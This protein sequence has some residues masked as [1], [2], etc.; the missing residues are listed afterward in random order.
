MKHIDWL[1][2]A[3]GIAGSVL[4]IEGYLQ[5]II[6]FLAILASLVSLSINIAKWWKKAKKDGKIDVEEMDELQSII[7]KEGDELNELQRNSH[8]N[9][10]DS[11]K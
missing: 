10:G 1:F 7:E 8:T 3:I 9:Q 11:K 4:A 6:L 5:I 2:N